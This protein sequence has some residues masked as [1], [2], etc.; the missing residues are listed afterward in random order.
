MTED[1]QTLAFRV[2]EGDMKA[3]EQL[4]KLTGKSIYFTCLSFVKNEYDAK[5]MVQETYLSALEKIDSLKDKSKISSW[6]N[7]IAVN[8]CKDF[9]KKKVPEPLD[10]EALEKIQPE[11]DECFLAED[12]V[13]DS[14]KR[15][16]VM[17][18]MQSVLSEAQYQ[19]VILYYFNGMS[20]AEIAE[21]M[22]CPTGTVTYRLSTARAK[23]KKG[24]LDYENKNDDRLHAIVG[25]PFLTRLL[26]AEAD[27]LEAPPLNPDLFSNVKLPANKA[28]KAAENGVKKMFS[29][30]KSKVI[31]GVIAVAVVGGGIIA[32]VMLTSSNETEIKNT[33]ISYSEKIDAEKNS[34]VSYIEENDSKTEVSQESAAEE[35]SPVSETEYDGESNSRFKYDMSDLDLESEPHYPD[36]ITAG[37]KDYEVNLTSNTIAEDI[38]SIITEEPVIDST[39]ISR[40]L[41]YGK[42]SSL[43][44]A[45]SFSWYNGNE[46]H[47]AHTYIEFTSEDIDVS[48]LGIT[49]DSTPQEIAYILGTPIISEVKYVGGGNY[50]KMQSLI[51]YDIE[52]AGEAISDVTV[53]YKN[54]SLYN[55]SMK[56][57]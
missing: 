8:K 23:I 14:E 36:T 6:L 47:L 18:I 20:A 2:S 25:I 30:V 38:K 19:T 51:W 57:D 53:N 4:Y 55:M 5:D 46:K 29:T 3:F 54:G 1:L 40:S 42:I 7:K 28:A 16:T 10:D 37:Y 56:F 27:S 49:K 24:V 21:I 13:T 9:L 48:L 34:I 26:K 50:D 35:V 43:W 33:D 15:Q 32:G 41:E 12:Y 45:L 31:A 52:I 11:E 17:E 39:A 44:N 22:K